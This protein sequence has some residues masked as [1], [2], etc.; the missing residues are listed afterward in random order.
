MC[1]RDRTVAE[2][3]SL[4]EK[5]AVR[6]RLRQ[7]TAHAQLVE[8]VTLRIR[9]VL[10]ALRFDGLTYEVVDGERIPVSIAPDGIRLPLKG[11]RDRPLLSVDCPSVDIQM[12]GI[13]A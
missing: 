13:S 7:H 10:L 11:S 2:L 3:E 12:I 1:I 8:Q 5:P 6:I 9:Q 4:Q